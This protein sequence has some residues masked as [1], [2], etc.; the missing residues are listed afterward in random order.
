MNIL[1]SI[2]LEK[3]YDQKIALKNFNLSIPEGQIFGLLGPNGAGKTTFIR[4]V[5]GILLPDS[6]EVLFMGNR[7]S[8]NSQQ[9][10]GYLPEERGLYKKMRVEEHLIYL[11]KLKGLSHQ[12][13]KLQTNNWLIRLNLDSWRKKNIEEL[14]KGMQ[15][16][17]QFIATVLNNPKLLILDEP[18]SGFDPLNADLL[19]EEILKLRDQGTTIL[20]STHR[21]ETVEELCESMVLINNS[22]KILE[23][24]VEDIKQSHK[25]N[26]FEVESSTPLKPD[27]AFE[28]KFSKQG[29]DKFYYLI[30]PLQPLS[31]NQLLSQLIQDGNI[32]SFKEKLPELREIFIELVKEGVKS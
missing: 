18:F 31:S 10:I 3:R 4:L 23:G 16:K 26:L 9:H 15:Q 21:M 6:G 17:V 30:H 25:Q 1:E 29:G 7:L 19:T 14:S 28:I 20:F 12:D 27:S 32:L 24:K 2:A 11:G 8:Y 13:A 22:E 5:T